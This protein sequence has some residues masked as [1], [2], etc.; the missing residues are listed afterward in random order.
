V[1][2]QTPS[3]AKHALGMFAA[4]D[5]NH[6]GRMSFVEFLVMYCPWLSEVAAKQCINKFGAPWEEAPEMRIKISKNH[7]AE[8]IKVG[9]VTRREHI[10]Q[11]EVSE[12]EEVYDRWV[13]AAKKAGS[14]I[15]GHGRGMSFRSLKQNVKGVDPYTLGEWHHKSGHGQRLSK[16]EFVK[17]IASH[18]GNVEMGVPQSLVRSLKVA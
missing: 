5:A 9:Q 2:Q 6:N 3:L 13:A 1:R 18:Y 12:I 11:E 14:P 7:T 8:S 17:L 16:K 15:K 4:A 10:T